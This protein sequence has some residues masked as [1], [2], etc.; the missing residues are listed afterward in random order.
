MLSCSVAQLGHAAGRNRGDGAEEVREGSRERCVRHS[1]DR[2]HTP[3]CL[4]DRVEEEKEKAERDKARENKPADIG[5]ED[6][7]EEPSTAAAADG[8]DAKESKA[9]RKAAAASTSASAVIVIRGEF[10]EIED[11]QNE[12]A[13]IDLDHSDVDM[14]GEEDR[15]VNIPAAD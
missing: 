14:E 1:V 3:T 8:K 6:K 2:A 13:D 4:S 10:S 5:S 9:G 7:E 15:S 11:S 12:E